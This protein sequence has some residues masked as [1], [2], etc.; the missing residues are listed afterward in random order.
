MLSAVEVDRRVATSIARLLLTVFP[1]TKTVDELTAE[2]LG[3]LPN[4]AQ[5]AG[6]VIYDKDEIVAFAGGMA[7]IIE[8]GADRRR[9]KVLALFG[10]A[11][12]PE[13]R[14]RGYGREIVAAQLARVDAGEFALGLWQT[15]LPEF[16]E[17]FGAVRVA[18]KFIN[19]FASPTSPAFW[20]TSVMVYPPT[21]WRDQN[22][23]IDLLGAGY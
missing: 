8:H 17:K 5:Y 13:F 10:V 9:E 20:D 7:R 22:E 18:N 14:G 16:Y 12:A 21:K 3:N 4:F 19:S 23:V 2:M 15:G 11:T 1:Q 6:A